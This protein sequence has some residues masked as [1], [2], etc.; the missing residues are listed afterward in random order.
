MPL[1]MGPSSSPSSARLRCC[2]CR[3]E[4]GVAGFRQ[5]IDKPGNKRRFRSDDDKVR[6]NFIGEGKQT[7]II[8]GANINAAAMR[9][10][11][12]ASRGDDKFLGKR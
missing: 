1:R 2:R 12:G 7:V 9:C 8:L 6:T 5:P 10:H 3:S 11:R 4:G